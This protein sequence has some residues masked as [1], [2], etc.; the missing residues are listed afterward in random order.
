M[1]VPAAQ[2]DTF[3]I[4]AKGGTASRAYGF[5]A[6]DGTVLSADEA[7]K[8]RVNYVVTADN[9]LTAYLVVNDTQYTGTVYSGVIL[10]DRVAANE[11][12]AAENRESTDSLA[13]SLMKE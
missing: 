10:A 11:S 6:S 8:T 7:S 12:A 9:A 5:V 4:T 2:G 1:V 3:T 13:W